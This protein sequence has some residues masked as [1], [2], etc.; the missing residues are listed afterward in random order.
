MASDAFTYIDGLYIGKAFPEDAVRSTIAY[1]PRAGDLFI[2]TYP[3]RS[4]TTYSPT[5]TYRTTRR[6]PSCALPFLEIQGADAAAHALKPGAFKT[7]LPFWM[8]PYSPDAKYIYVARNP[9]DCCVSFYH[10]TKNFDT[11]H[12]EDGTFDDFLDK[13]VDGKVDFGDY[14]DHLLSWYEHR[15][16][17]N[18]LFVTFEDIKPKLRDDEALLDKIVN[19]VSFENMK[20]SL[21][22][23]YDAV[24]T[25]VDAVEQRSSHKSDS[26]S[27]AREWHP[28]LLKG[29]EAFKAYFSQ[30][31][32]GNFARKGAVGDWKEHFSDDHVA[33]MKHYIAS[34]T[35]GSDVMSLWPDVPVD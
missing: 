33:K 30:P 13:F 32:K 11:Y 34:K 28:A 27:Q 23:K 26:P 1:K 21:N 12:Y 29:F 9:Y 31:M 19:A 15:D 35:A 16:D 2:V 6:T 7:H 5:A 8:N 17:R 24:K 3:N 14:F 18:V 22:S 4:S 20:D 25:K 10:H